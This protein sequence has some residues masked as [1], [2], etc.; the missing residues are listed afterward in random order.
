MLT[1]HAQQIKLMDA[2]TFIEK[3]KDKFEPK[4]KL[5]E[6]PKPVESR[7]VPEKATYD[8]KHQVLDIPIEPPVT[9][10]AGET[11][12]V[13]MLTQKIV[14]DAMET[15]RVN[16]SLPNIQIQQFKPTIQ[17][18]VES[19][20]QPTTAL[21]RVCVVLKNDAQAGGRLDAWTVKRITTH[22][23]NHGWEDAG[24]E[25]AVAQLIRWEILKK[26]SN[27]YL[28]FYPQRIQVTEIN[29]PIEAS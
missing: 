10:K 4:P 2:T 29:S 14:D 22:I 26:Q 13:P 24:I 1:K 28:R 7:L 11:K 15:V 6:T 19:L 17:L 23:R 9:F 18:P 20:E 25:E 5:V 3:F 16:Q 21:G 8:T 27:N 12:P